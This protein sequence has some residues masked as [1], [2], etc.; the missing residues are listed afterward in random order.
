MNGCCASCGV[1]AVTAPELFGGFGPDGSL[2]DGVEQC[3]VKRQPR[4]D[5][6]LDAMMATMATQDL[7]CIRYGGSDPEIIT[8]LDAVGAAAQ[9]DGPDVGYRCASCGEWHDALVRSGHSI[10]ATGL[11]P[12]STARALRRRHGKLVVTDGPFVE[13]KEVVGGFETLECRDIDEALAIAGRF[14]ALDSGATVEVRPCVV[15]DMCKA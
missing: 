15:G 11:Q 1:P 14:P 12:A 6:E 2:A 3:W 4:S 10:G 13:T 5:V 7:G 8:R 9:V